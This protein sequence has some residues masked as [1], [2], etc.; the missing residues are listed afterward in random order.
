MMYMCIH[1]YTC[2]CIHVYMYTCVHVYIRGVQ[3]LFVSDLRHSDWLP[4][5]KTFLDR[6]ILFKDLIDHNIAPMITVTLHLAC[7]GEG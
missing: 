5:G 6:N 4:F 2:T 3:T 1:V 7:V